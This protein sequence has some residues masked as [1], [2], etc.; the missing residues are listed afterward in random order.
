MDRLLL[1][2]GDIP[3]HAPVLLAWVLLRH[4]LQPEESS[5]VVRRI[6]NTALQ[7]GVFKHI[8]TMLK[9]LGVSGNIVREHGEGLYFE[10]LLFSL[11]FFI[12]CRRFLFSVQQSQQRCVS[13]G[14]C[15]L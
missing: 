11:S 5:P 3:H 10:W 6:G 1:T 7:L 12:E 15:H 9:S 4:T 8:S 14:F 2:F 13:T